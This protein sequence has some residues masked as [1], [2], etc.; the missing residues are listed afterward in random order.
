MADLGTD[1]SCTLDSP[2]EMGEVTGRTCLAQAIVRRLITPRGRLIDDPDYGYDLSQY[3]ND[4]LARSDLARIQFESE[5][6]CTKD[7]RVLS[8]SVVL[9]V[10]SGTMTAIV[11]LQDADG[12]FTLVLA[13]NDVTVQ[14]LTVS[15]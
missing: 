15:P 13:I 2:P 7:E 8:A 5:S 6:E 4:D 3:L 9:T 11:T 14:L 12:P 1:I 10:A